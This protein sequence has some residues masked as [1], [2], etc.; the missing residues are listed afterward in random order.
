MRRR[1]RSHVAFAAAVAAGLLV[2]TATPTAA[3]VGIPSMGIVG[4]NGS[5]S[6]TLC[7]SGSSTALINAWVFTVEGVRS[8]GSPVLE[9]RNGTGRSFSSCVTVG[10]N[11]SL[12]GA[13]TGT[14]S[15]AGSGPEVTGAFG[16]VWGWAP[17]V[18]PFA[19]GTG[20]T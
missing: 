1:L 9:V 2:H 14:L 15:F 16:A 13:G 12:T 5:S 11:G 3:A 20:L 4:S 6:V 17:V 8:D 7:A 18:G 19:A 10:T